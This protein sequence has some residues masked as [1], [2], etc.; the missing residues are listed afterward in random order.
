ME[1]HEKYEKYISYL[2]NKNCHTIQHSHSN[3]LNHLI[4]TFNIL[5][6]WRQPEDLCVAGMFHNIYGNKYFNPNLNIS[7]EEIKNLIGESAENLVYRFVNSD[8][9]KIN[10]SDD[11]E[12][13][14]LNLANYLDQK[15]LFIVED[16]LYDK[17]SSKNIFNYFK[18][19]GWSFDGKSIT[20]IST[21]WSYSL[22]YKHEYENNFLNLSNILLKKYGLNKIFKLSRAYASANTYGY[23]GEFHTDDYA[24]EYNEIVTV[25]FYLNDEWSIDFGGETFFLNQN[26]DEIENAIIPKPARAVIFDGFI[27]H[28]ARHLSKLCNEL[29]IV[30]TFK[31]ELINK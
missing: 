1:K 19:L 16:N 22:N 23:V 3:F 27:H 30:L 20:N 28:G 4:N 12:L 26:K 18:N 14:I 15:K 2:Y 9:D 31:Y 24:K 29:R 11:N 10:E 13:I 21:K 8:R 5:K 25:M 17:N 7:R 6:K